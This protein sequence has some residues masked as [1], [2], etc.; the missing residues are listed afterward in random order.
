MLFSSPEPI[1]AGMHERCHQCFPPLF[2]IV[3]AEA[4]RRF[5]MMYCMCVHVYAHLDQHLQ[6]EF[7]FFFFLIYITIVVL[8]ISAA[9]FGMNGTVLD[10]P[11][12]LSPVNEAFLALW[13]PEMHSRTPERS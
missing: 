10:L 3:A 7:D 13:L 12:P 9:S 6:I 1:R 11:C 4:S 2:L 5:I 8:G